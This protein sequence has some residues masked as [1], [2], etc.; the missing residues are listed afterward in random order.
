M[1]CTSIGNT[2]QALDAVDGTVVWKDGLSEGYP[3]EQRR[4][5]SNIG[6]DGHVDTDDSRDRRRPIDDSEADDCAGL[7]R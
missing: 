7:R 1:S 6:S 3:D 4:L 5:D 2:L